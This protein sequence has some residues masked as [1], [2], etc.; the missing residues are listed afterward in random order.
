MIP[1]FMKLHF[2]KKESRGI[3]LW[4]PVILVW[5]LVLLFMLA[6]FPLVILATIFTWNQGWGKMLIRFYPAFFVLLFSL[7][8]LSLDIQTGKENIY[9]NFV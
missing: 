6:L 8:G 2:R 9:L 4:F 1:M 3:N 5:I 7:S